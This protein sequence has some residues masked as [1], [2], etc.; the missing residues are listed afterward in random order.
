VVQG[1]LLKS[2]DFLATIDPDA[3]EEVKMAST[4]K[5]FMNG[6]LEAALV[7]ANALIELE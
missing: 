6:S 5:R 3:A 7:I 1:K 4:Y 2:L